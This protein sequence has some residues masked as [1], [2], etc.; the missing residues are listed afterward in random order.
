MWWFGSA[1][2]QLG[3]EAHAARG[4][5]VGEALAVAGDDRRAT[6]LDLVELVELGSR[7]GG[8]HVREHVA[9]ALRDPGVLVHLAAEEGG[10]VRALLA[11]DL[12]AARD[13]GVG[14]RPARRPRRS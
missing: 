6:R 11:R 14:A 9:G 5:P 8:Q 4:R 3:R 12:G 7:I 13:L 1:L 10:A 2:R